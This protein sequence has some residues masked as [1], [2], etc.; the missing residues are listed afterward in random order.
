[1]FLFYLY[2]RNKKLV[3]HH[4]FNAVILT[5]FSPLVGIDL[6]AVFHIQCICRLYG[7]QAFF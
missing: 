6:F 7:K 3:Q 2:G 4:V 1:M 5:L